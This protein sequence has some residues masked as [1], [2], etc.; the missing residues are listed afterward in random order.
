MRVE[1]ITPAELDIDSRSR[2]QH[3]QAV[4]THLSS[5]FLSPTFTEMVSRA[6]A[7]TR[8]ALVSNGVNTAYLPF[9]KR[10]YGHAR[11]VGMGLSDMQGIIAA[12]DTDIDMAELLHAT[13]LKSLTFDHW[14]AE[15][16]N[17][18]TT[19]P[20]AVARDVSKAID[21]TAGF[22]AYLGDQKKLS[23]DLLRSTARKERK[24][25]REHGPVRFIFHKADHGALDQL[26]FWKSLQYRNTGRRDRFA[27]PA[28]RRLV[29]ELL[30]VQQRDF[31]APLSLLM[32]G[33]HLVAAHFGLCA[34]GT[35]AGWFPSYDPA[36]AAF[37]PGSMLFFRLT[38]VL[39]DLGVRMFDLGKGDEP[40]KDRLCN[41]RLDLLAGSVAATRH[42]HAVMTLRRWPHERVMSTVLS[43]PRLRATSRSV[44]ARAGAARQWAFPLERA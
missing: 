6:R 26:L 25:E 39:P 34:N 10:R 40:Y 27:N 8:I 18:M 31:A 23:K 4:N 15:Q 30:D 22:A 43:S 12:P 1:V 9:E 42:T 7:D 38:Q 32:A 29:H 20:A 41:S 33:D 28:N 21:L 5:P 3:I 24:L 14:V 11:A 36:F 17:W 16:Q 2:W 35:L 37:S 13:G 44:L 19:G